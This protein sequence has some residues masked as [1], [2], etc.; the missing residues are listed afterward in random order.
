MQRQ[1]RTNHQ[2]GIALA[3]VLVIAL[4]LATG[5][6]AFLGL[7]NLHLVRAR[8]DAEAVRAFYVAQAA[9]EKAV[10]QLKALYARGKGHTPEELAEIAPPP[11]EG[12]IFDE[13]TVAPVGQAYSG[14]LEWGTFKGIHGLIQKIGISAAVSSLG[15][16]NVK[17]GIKQEVEAQFIPVFQFAIFYNSDDLEILPGAPMTVLGPAH[18]NKN[19]YMAAEPSASLSFDSK[20]T[21]VGDIYHARKDSDRLLVGEVQIRDGEGAYQSMQNQ[22]GTWLDST[23]PDWGLES[24]DRWDGNVA[25]AAHHVSPLRL[26][27]A[28]PEEPCALV[29]RADPADTPEDE[30]LKYYYRADLRIIDGNAYDRAGSPVDLRYPNPQNPTQTLN[31][32]S[33]KTFYNYREGKTISVTQIDIAKLNAS[34]KSP[35]NGIVYVSDHRSNSSTQDAVRLVNG[36]ELPTDGLTVATDNPL[37]IWGDYNTTN[38]RPASVDCDALNILS[39]NWKDENSQ[40]S[41]DY[42]VASNTQVNAAIIAGNTVTSP[43]DYNGGVENMPRFLENWSGKTLTYRGSLVSAWVSQIATGSWVYGAPYYTA[44][45]RNWS[46]DTDLSDPTKAP[47]GEPSVFTVEVACWQYE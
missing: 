32:I 4:V 2:N 26:P 14:V 39:N 35:A 15:Y 9:I 28:T 23:D 40:K 7:T 36:K 45:N 43:G 18:S 25:S 27:L 24:Q 20:V 17:V 6:A 29:Q 44:P 33:T 41:L 38:K 47:P 37:Y 1:N 13:F 8:R 31:P 19:I 5:S 34:G 10:A 12:F 30:A 46:Y 3:V 11:F 16:D 42:R 21:C 22:D